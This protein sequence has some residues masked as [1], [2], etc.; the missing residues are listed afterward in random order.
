MPSVINNS[1]QNFYKWLQEHN[2]KFEIKTKIIGFSATP[3]LIYP[4]DTILSRYTIYQA[5]NDRVILKP[6]IVW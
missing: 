4:L 6:R 2:S 3:E 1:T 5:Y